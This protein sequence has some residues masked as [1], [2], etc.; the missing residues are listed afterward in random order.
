MQSNFDVAATGKKVT[1]EKG[2]TF[3]YRGTLHTP[4]RTGWY[5]FNIGNYGRGV[6]FAIDG[7]MVV[8]RRIPQGFTW[9]CGRKWLEGN[10]DYSFELYFSHYSNSPSLQLYWDP[11]ADIYK[12]YTWKSRCWKTIDYFVFAGSNSDEIM[13]GLYTVTGKVSIL[14]KW[15]MAY[16]HCQAIPFGTENVDGFNDEGFLSLVRDYRQKQIPCDMLVQDFMWWTVMGSHIFRPDCYPDF[17]GRLQKVH[18][19]DFKLMISVWPLFQDIPAEGYKGKLT[20]ADFK[21]KK[22]LK[23]KGLLIGIMSIL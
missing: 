1:G 19:K 5:Y 4:K 3:L 8:E 14:P 10:K 9:N 17:Q 6:R 12:Q 22:E 21:N 16:I 13:N 23:D 11:A 20:D 2:V 15:S 7:E 18:D